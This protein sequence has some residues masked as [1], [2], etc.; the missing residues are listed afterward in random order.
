VNHAFRH[1]GSGPRLGPNRA[2]R[3][4]AA[5]RRCL[6]CLAFFDD[7][8]EVCPTDGSRLVPTLEPEGLVGTVIDDR[9]RL[10]EPIG[11]GA[12]G[13][14][15]RARHER[16]PRD[17]A[18]KVLSRRHAAMPRWVRRFEVEVRAAASLDNPHIV[19]VID[20]GRNDRVGYFIVM[21]LLRGEDLAQRMARGEPLH[22]F[23]IFKIF[24]EAAQAIGAAH[25][26][27]IVHRDIKPSNLFLVREP[28][29]SRGYSVRLLDFGIAQVPAE[30]SQGPGGEGEV[31]APREIL[32]TPYAM[33]PEQIRG[34]PVTAAADI[35][36][37]GVLLH[38]MLAGEPPFEEPTGDA[39]LEM[40]LYAT[41]PS[42]DELDQCRWVPAELSSLVRRMLS[43][44][45]ARRPPD[46]PTLLA[47]LEALWPRVEAAWAAHAMLGDRAPGRPPASAP[48]QRSDAAGDRGD[49]ESAR[50]PKVLVVDDERVMRVLIGRL[51][52]N[53]GY[54]VCEASSGEEALAAVAR[55]EV[56]DAVVLDLLL[57]G[58]H[59]LD[60]LQQLRAAHAA[61][62]IVVCSGLGS[63]ALRELA[64]EAGAS[65][66]VD[67]ARELP[68]IAELF[69]GLLDQA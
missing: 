25:G 10:L 63:D 31:G 67:K 21:E 47:E 64:A 69:S 58:T 42:L 65:A 28:S 8:Q 2:P 48:G 68:R 52:T 61:L 43:K 45:P 66:F 30:P 24:Q 59:G 11:S 22:I 40:H 53:H 41:P 26:A 54:D 51:L 56:P 15:F 13:F 57:P 55:G 6:R 46:I 38:D 60:V 18:V 20:F 37:L 7:G 27:G 33:A 39:A 44:R 4:T 5:V 16:L 1:Q 17:L 3:Y 19:E 49:A 34:E 9:Y 50:A 35:Y 32:G 29:A 36:A 14:V 12:S 62:P 23:D